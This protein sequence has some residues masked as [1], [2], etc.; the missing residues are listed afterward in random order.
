VPEVSAIEVVE[1][2]AEATHALRR[3]VLR[4]GRPDQDVNF[5]EDHLDAAF[6]LGARGNDGSLLGVASFSPN[7]TEHRAGKVAYQLRGMAVLDEYQGFGIGRRLLDEAAARLRERGV[8]VLWAN[9]RDSALGFYER[10]G[11][12]V[13]G[14]VFVTPSGIPHHVVV[15]DF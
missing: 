4:R 1:L 15:Y 9:G 8:E 5:P 3:E 11:M 14:D 6:H 10:W 12:E 7:E 13:V 2:P